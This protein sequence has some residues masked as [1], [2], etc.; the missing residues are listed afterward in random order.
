MELVVV[1]IVWEYQSPFFEFLPSSCRTRGVIVDADWLG[2]SEPIWRV[3]DVAGWGMRSTSSSS[4]T[5]YFFFNRGVRFSTMSEL[6]YNVFAILKE[7]RP[8]VPSSTH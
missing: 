4:S 7:S 6:I 8:T 3:R 5:M 1:A 2:T